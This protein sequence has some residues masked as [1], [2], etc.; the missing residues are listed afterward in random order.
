MRR[1]AYFYRS[2]YR[3]GRPRWDSD[4]PRT[5]LVALVEGRVPGRALDLGCGTGTDAL[6]LASKGW[7][8]IGVD[9]APEAIATASRRA[10]EAGSTAHFVV[11]DVSQLTAANV[12]GPFDLIVDIGCFH[13]V[14]N[15]LRDNYARGVAQ[16][17]RPGADFYLT[18]IDSPPLTWRL[19]GAS[20]VSLAELRRRFGGDFDVSE[21]PQSAGEH[22]GM[23]FRDYHLVR[24]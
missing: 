23:H 19:V 18:G 12:R 3:R 9:F 1:D 7:D 24:K 15:R 13:A 14:P 5:Q 4:E 6:F 17:A 22:L 21:D 20:G 11:G 8:V 2:A 16:V 10:R